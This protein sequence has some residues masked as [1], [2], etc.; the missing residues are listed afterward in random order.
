MSTAGSRL[1]I[2]T[3]WLLGNARNH[4]VELTNHNVCF[5]NSNINETGTNIAHMLLIVHFHFYFFV[6]SW[7]NLKKDISC[8]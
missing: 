5:E 6:P 4:V 2:E 1:Y 8:T 3:R 7:K